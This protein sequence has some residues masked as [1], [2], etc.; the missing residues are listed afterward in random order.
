LYSVALMGR[1]A[2]HAGNTSLVLGSV[3]VYVWKTV[4]VFLEPEL[5]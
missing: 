3:Y 1:H 5:I 2:K 4:N